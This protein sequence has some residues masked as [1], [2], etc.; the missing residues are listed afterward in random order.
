MASGRTASTRGPRRQQT[1]SR[2][3]LKRKL[4]SKRKALTARQK[5][6]RRQRRQME[7][8]RT[9]NLRGFRAQVSDSR[10]AQRR[11]CLRRPFSLLKNLREEL[12]YGSSVLCGDVEGVR[13]I[14]SCPRE[15]CSQKTVSTLG[16]H[17][18]RPCSWLIERSRGLDAR[19]YAA[20]KQP[21]TV[22]DSSQAQY[23]S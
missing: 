17:L 20:R 10:R 13:Q 12:K 5:D 18:Q 9:M 3:P 8:S 15:Q 14:R 19:P 22:N 1:C 2:Y 6:R 4:R 16:P 23:S 11:H 21:R 7:G